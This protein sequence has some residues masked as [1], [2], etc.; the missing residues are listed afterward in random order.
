MSKPALRLDWCD[1]AAAKYAV[2]RWHYS[3][4]MP[5][6]KL[7]KVGVWEGGEFVGVVIFGRGATPHIGSPYGLPQTQICELVRVALRRHQWPVSRILAI[8]VRMLKRANP[9]LRLIVS[10]ADTKQGHHGGIYQAAGWT[11]AGSSGQRRLRVHGRVVHPRSMGS[12]YGVGG[13]SIAWLRANVDAHAEDIRDP[14]KHRYLM[15]L[16]ADM[17]R[18]IAA[19]AQP[20]PK[21]PKHSQDDAAA[22]PGR[23]GHGSSPTRA[24][25][26]AGVRT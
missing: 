16:D 26:T 14:D 18:Q 19:L 20:Y 23:R 12:K 25:S 24:L 2:Q 1:H 8:A 22:T 5:G 15:P 11:Y 13:Q 4:A 9:G 10:F 3:R 7:S 17:R 6:G 21:R